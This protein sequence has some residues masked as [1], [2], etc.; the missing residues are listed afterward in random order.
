MKKRFGI[1]IDGTLTCPTTFVPFIN[2]TLNRNIT[3]DDMKQYDLT[4]LMGL[5]EEEFWKWM[6]EMEPVIY[7]DAPLAQGAQSIVQK[8]KNEFDLY[9]ISARRQHL[10]EITQNWFSKQAIDYNH[11]ELIG[12]HNKIASVKKHRIDLFFEDKH[13]N[14]CD[15]SE[16]CKIPVILFDTPYNREPIPQNVYR[17]QNWL[18]ANQVVQS[19]LERM[20]IQK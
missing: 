3:L 15:I 17:V 5:T 19:L 6:D 11:L 2:E 14:A 1:D 7:K 10:F 8:W 9:F 20:A 4:P 12:T 13:D 16:E 18:E